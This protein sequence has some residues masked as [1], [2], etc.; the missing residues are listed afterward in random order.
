MFTE[1]MEGQSRILRAAEVYIN[2]A[3]R[4]R[5]IPKGI[6]TNIASSKEYLSILS[7]YIVNLKNGLKNMSFPMG[8][9]AI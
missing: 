9:S 6:K 8:P 3:K 4:L 2:R 1:G 7:K 5:R